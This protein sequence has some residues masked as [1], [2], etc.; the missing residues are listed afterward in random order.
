MLFRCDDCIKETQL[1]KQELNLVIFI[2][3]HNQTHARWLPRSRPRLPRLHLLI[4]LYETNKPN[5]PL[6][7]SCIL[8]AS[9][10]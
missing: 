5:R 7:T 2:F 4:R 3:A 1:T 10:W 8:Y 6:V 9:I